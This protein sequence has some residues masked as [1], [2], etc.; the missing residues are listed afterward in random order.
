MDHQPGEVPLEDSQHWQPA[1]LPS[2]LPNVDLWA[3]VRRRLPVLDAAEKA[4]AKERSE[5]AIAWNRTLPVNRLPNELLV[6]IF[7][8][9]ADALSISRSRLSG[10]YPS[11]QWMKL[12]L[13]CHYWRD[14]A[15]ASPKLWRVIHMRSPAYTERALALS[16]P[17]TIDVS[18]ALHK[19][20]PKNLELLQPHAH[21]LRSL[22]FVVVET[23]WKSSIIAL[24]QNDNGVPALETLQLPF[25]WRNAGLGE[26]KDG[27]FVDLQLTAERC[28]RL[29]SLAVAHT[30][31]PQ[32]IE[33]YARLRKL[34]LRDCRCAFSFDHFLDALDASSN[35]ENLVLDSFLERIEGDWVGRAAT[36]RSPLSLRHLKLL[37]VINHPPVYTSR[38]LSHILLSPSVSVRIDCEAA[39]PLEV[40]LTETVAAMLPSNPA[41]VLPALAL[42]KEVVVDVYGS[43]YLLSGFVEPRVRGKDLITLRLGP[44][45][46]QDWSGFSAHGARDL[47]SVFASAPL[48]TL[49]FTGDCGDVTVE[50]WAEIFT[51][52]PLLDTLK[53][54]QVGTT[55]TAFAGLMAAT[56]LPDLPVPCPSLRSVTVVGPFF[57]EAIDVMLQCL[58]DRA[59]KGY[60]LERVGMELLGMFEGDEELMD[61]AYM[62]QLRE[63]VSEAKYAFTLV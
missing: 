46:N 20:N 33:V 47:L 16:S 42:A 2:G 50:T 43:E 52:Y 29:Q 56:P 15:Y 53:L 18:F 49:D 39:D 61:T 10:R 1:R 6:S 26:P 40:D 5:L 30:V 37:Q 36:G 17:A 51:R 21:R 57:E 63:L 11:T 4:I 22:H 19:S 25:F 58:R 45:L 48:T 14:V 24:L 28:P 54:G 60:R 23:V 34:S 38:F 8:Q 12:I 44:S 32:D 13:V 27:E 62:P 35:L 31:A 55:E 9:V 41:I 7:A 59:G 3:R